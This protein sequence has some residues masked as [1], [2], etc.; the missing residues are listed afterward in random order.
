[1]MSA[2]HALT[3]AALGRLCRTRRQAFLLGALSHLAADML[4]HR[5]LDIPAE[6]ALLSGALAVVAGAAGSES[7][8]FAG[9]V[10]AAFPDVENLIGRLAG[11]PEN[12][13]LIPTH[14]G[15]HGNETESL[16]PQL[17]LAAGALLVCLAAP[18]CKGAP[19]HGNCCR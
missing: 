13:L 9:A 18:R 4:P 14:R 10:G 1:M 3:G 15:Y 8:E 17:A 11:I 5:D 2:V 7:P 12:R 6:A 16:G 19:E